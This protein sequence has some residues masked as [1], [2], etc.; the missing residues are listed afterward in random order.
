MTYSK[1]QGI[2]FVV[3]LFSNSTIWKERLNLNPCFLTCCGIWRAI[4]RFYQLWFKWE[5][6]RRYFI[7]ICKYKV[8]PSAAF[9][10]M[11]HHVV[12]IV[13]LGSTTQYLVLVPL[14]FVWNVLPVLYCCEMYAIL[15]L[16]YSLYTGSEVMEHVFPPL[17]CWPPQGPMKPAFNFKWKIFTLQN[18]A[19]EK[20]PCMTM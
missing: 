12:V 17:A 7:N 13:S 20:Q 16:W 11:F 14:C 19:I 8:T 10:L 6:G 9:H 1:T 4:L 2:V 5:C 15:C 18:G 3:C